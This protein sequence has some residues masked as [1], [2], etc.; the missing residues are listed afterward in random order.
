MYNIP[1]FNTGWSPEK[2]AEYQAKHSQVSIPELTFD[3]TEFQNDLDK[4]MRWADRVMR[5]EARKAKRE[6]NKAQFGNS[7]GMSAGTQNAITTASKALGTYARSD[8]NAGTQLLGSAISTAASLNPTTAIIDAGIEGLNALAKAFDVENKEYNMGDVATIGMSKSK[9]KLNNFLNSKF[10]FL[11]AFAPEYDGPLQIQNAEIATGSY[12]GLINKNLAFQNM[13]GR[14]IS[15][16][17]ELASLGKI[18]DKQVKKLNDVIYDQKRMESNYAP[19]L[20][21][22]NNQMIFNG[23][24][25]GNSF[26]LGA[27]HGGTIPELDEVRSIMQSLQ[28]KKQEIQE[29]QK[30]QLGGKMNMIVTGALHARKHN[31]EE[32]NPNLEGEITKKG[33]PV[34]TFEEGGE[35]Q[36]QQAEV[37]REEWIIEKSSTEYIEDLYNS[38][39]LAK[40]KVELDKIALEC[41]KFLVKQLLLNTDDPGKIIKNTI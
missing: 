28:S 8:Y 33:I 20:L 30:F 27:K 17:R 10:S 29:T 21:A 9:A 7:L 15:G 1:E 26:V 22:V 23:Y 16:G 25:P 37:E 3:D 38:Y 18:H 34:V 12:S 39:N 36:S 35:V 14:H 6:E 31:L 5:I 11:G 24:T 19:Q 41:G 40:N 32:L 13:K 2:F 4:A